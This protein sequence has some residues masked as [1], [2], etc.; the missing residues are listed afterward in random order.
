MDTKGLTGA[1]AL[2]RLLRQMGVERIFASPGSEWAPV[3]EHLA[4]PYGS[5]TEI[6]VYVSSRH[7]EVAVAMASGYAKAS[8]K[9]PAVMIHTTVGA[10]HAAMALRGARHEQISMVVLAGESVGFS[11]G[12]DHDLG[13]QWLR[14]LSDV[15]GPAKLV[16]PC[17]KWGFALN[18]SAVLPATIQRAC[19]LAMAAPPGP[20]FV[21]V[22]ME[23]LLETLTTNPPAS[24]GFAHAPA[25]HPR[26]ID[27]LA[28][29]LARAASPLIVTEEVGRS[30][31]AV[32][33][34]VSLAER[35][36]A[37]VI[38]AWH[39]GYANFPRMHPLYGGGG[40]AAVVAGDP[41]H[42]HV[43][44]LLA[45]AAPWHPAPSAPRPRPKGAVL[46]DNPPRSAL[47]F[48]GY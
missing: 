39:P 3:W 24:A 30:V 16:E 15:G 9:L 19:Q 18:S 22:P 2:L 7:E 1:E 23:F 8:G 32:E 4:K 38:E 40:R 28:L 6:P 20:V 11:E 34:L 10:L 13:P 36:G 5:A 47:P 17:V 37:P 43:V 44:F 12:S 35:L 42:A 14:L 46:R 31:R 25:A 33:H 21:S 26:A 45:A 27:E 48:R 41:N 29:V